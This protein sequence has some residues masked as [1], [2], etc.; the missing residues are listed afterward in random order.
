MPLSRREDDSTS[1]CLI[2]REGPS[3][4][5]GP[6]PGSGERCRLCC[7]LALPHLPLCPPSLVQCRLLPPFFSS[8]LEARSTY[9]L[10]VD[11]S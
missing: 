4:T 7:S 6:R 3:P 11:L 10:V 1:E 2:S 8:S 5:A 9:S